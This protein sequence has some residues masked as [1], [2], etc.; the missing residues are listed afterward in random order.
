MPF[1]KITIITGLL[2]FAMTGYGQTIP[3]DS[4]HRA[5]TTLSVDTSFD[6]DDLLDEL[7]GFLDSIQAPRSFF[8]VSGS[9]ASGYFDFKTKSDTVLNSLKKAIFSPTIGYY[10]K[11]GPGI[12]FG[13]NMINDNNKLLFYQYSISPSF[14]FIR[15]KKAIGGISYTRYF[16][17]DSLSFYTTPLQNEVTGYFLYRKSWLQ[18]G[19]NAAYGWG[20]RSDLEKRTKFLRLRLIRRLKRL[21]INVTST[22]TTTSTDESIADFS[23]N[24]SVRHSFYWLNVL[25]PKDYI[26]FTPMLTLSAGTQKYG[27]NQTTGT[28]AI[29]SRNTGG[30]L[31][32]T[33][34]TNS[35][36]NQKFQPLS[37]TLSL[38]SEYTIGK[39]FIQPQVILDYYFPATSKQLS[40]LYTFNAGFMF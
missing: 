33:N 35:D 26:K 34:T 27:F 28:S 2:F 16:T 14:D 30:I 9:V 29:T 19:F 36:D 17:K 25:S 11:S 5:D 37:L 10:H 21:G 24:G 1:K 22:T 38:K 18:P 20:S 6:Y 23:L 8:L 3:A 15:G 4:V 7:D 12:T 40:M 13:G 39:F 31:L 32:N